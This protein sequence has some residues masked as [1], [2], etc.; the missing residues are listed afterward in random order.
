[1]LDIQVGAQGTI[2]LVGRFDASQADMAQATFRAIRQSAVADFA[3]LDYISSAGIAIIVE[4]YKRLT[5]SGHS[6]KLVNLNPRIRTVFGYAG[7]DKVMQI[8]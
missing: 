5:D 6:F 1:M 8:D 2:R 3:Q 4:T 7:L